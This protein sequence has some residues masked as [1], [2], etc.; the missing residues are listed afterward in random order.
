M[1]ETFKQEAQ[2]MQDQLVAWRR[3]FHAHP[4]IGFEE[5]RTGGI[6]AEYLQGLGL[7]VTTGVGKTGVTAIVEPDDLPA[8]A[9]TVMLRFDMDALSIQEIPDVAYRSTQ[10][11]VMHACGHDGHTAMGMG[12]AALLVRHRDE[13]NGRVKL[14]F[15]PA[16]EGL[17]GARAMVADGVLEN[18]RPGAAFG[19]HL[20]NQ[21]PLNQIVV[22]E[23]PLWA[24]AGIFNVTVHGKGGHGAEPHATIDATLIAAQILVSWQSIIA[25]NVRPTDSAVIT[26][27]SFH[28][29]SAANVVSEQATLY[30][31][32]R[33]F[34]D[35]VETL[36]LTRM[37]EMAQQIAAAYGGSVEF[38]SRRGINATVNDEAGAA[39]M[40]DVARR[41]V[42]ADQVVRID[43][44]MVGEDMSEFLDQVGGCFALVGAAPPDAPLPAPHHNPSFDFDESMLATGVALLAGSAY[45]YLARAAG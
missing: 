45:E 10:E 26:V 30:G 18:P 38:T 33:A 25:R 16:E 11:G 39:V 2:A 19:I 34:K 12:A 37:Q 15:Q 9:P 17:G 5:V 40:R 29:G 31:T 32:Y 3:D 35:D 28:S 8:D 23:G 42:D 24:I 21:L 43:P 20:W 13:L 1:H 44:M 22:Q 7:E 27:G 36:I 41:L 14:V 6:V 4:E